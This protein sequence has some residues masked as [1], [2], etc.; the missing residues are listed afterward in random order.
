MDRVVFFM[1]DENI[2]HAKEYSQKGTAHGTSE[3]DPFVRGR[4]PV[5]VRTIQ[6]LDAARDRRFPCEIWYPAAA[7]HAG[8]DIAPETQDTFTVPLPNAHRSQTAVRNATARPGTYP[9]IIFSH[10]SHGNRR[11]STFLCTHLSS[12]GYLVAAL[13]HSEIIA[14]ELAGKEGETDEQKT[15][16]VEAWIANRVPDIRFLLDHLLND[17]AWDSEAK[18]DPTRIGIVGHSFGGWTALAAVEVERRIGAVVA[19]A[20]G[21]N[22]RPKPG[23]IPGKL[24]FTWGRDVPTLYLVAENDVP[25]PLAGMYELFERTQATKQLI[26]LRR[27]DHMHFEDNV[28][29]MHEIVR[30]MP[31]TGEGAWIPK[32]MRPI[33]ELCSGDRGQLFVRGLTLCHMDA[34]LKRQEGAQRLLSGDIEAELA[35]RGVDVIAHRP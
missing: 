18:P 25:L 13:D 26:I 15:A 6:G 22:S 28:E 17:T 21:G 7:Q 29:E 4:F 19:L 8:Q 12:H 11:Q 31:H 24:S 9:L 16:R 20:P 30:A 5:G 27:A 3:Y 14:A 33:A 23:I 32:E 1:T 34:T 10:R 2:K 35:G